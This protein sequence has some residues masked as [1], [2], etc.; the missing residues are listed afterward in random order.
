MRNLTIAAVLLAAAGN[1]HAATNIVAN[2]GFEDPAI[3]SSFVEYNAPTN[4]I[5]NWVVTNGSVDL[6]RSPYTVNEGLQA[7]DLSGTSLGTISQAL[8]TAV[9][10]TYDLIFYFSNNNFS[11]AGTYSG[12]VSVGGLN[13]IFSHVEGTP[14]TQ[15]KGTFV[16]TGNDTLTFESLTNQNN[17]GVFLDSVNVSAA[18]EPATWLMMIAG[19][20]IAG[21]ALRR[22]RAKVNVRFAWSYR[23]LLEQGPPGKSGG[24]FFDLARLCDMGDRI[25]GVGYRR[26]KTALSATLE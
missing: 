21:A 7:L 11:G 23:E 8:T 2:G 6:V 15:F 22:K 25:T 16:G 14:W 9:G 10:Q 5:S 24:L 3:G 26:A 13:T 20:G 1:A 17:G 19:F 18:P 4:A 12:K